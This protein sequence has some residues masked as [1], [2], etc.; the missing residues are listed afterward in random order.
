MPNSDQDECPICNENL[1]K[2]LREWEVCGYHPR[3]RNCKK[4]TLKTLCKPCKR[5][6][7]KHEE[8]P[9]CSKKKINKN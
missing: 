9:R 8:L 4:F 3:C 5:L 2:Y 6:F 7:S 1:K